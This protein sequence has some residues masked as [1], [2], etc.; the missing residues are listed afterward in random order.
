M[1]R[2]SFAW[3]AGLLVLAV[4]VLAP[5]TVT[6]AD[7]PGCSD[8]SRLADGPDDAP[9][10]FRAAF[11]EAVDYLA[12][13]DH[14]GHGL[15][16]PTRIVTCADVR[17]EAAG[18]TA[19]Y[20][21]VTGRATRCVILVYPNGLSTGGIGSMTRAS[22]THEAFHCFM[23]AAL[24]SDART[25]YDAISGWVREGAAAWVGEDAVGG[26]PMSGTWWTS[27][28][29]EPGLRLF[30]RNYSG[31]GFYA[32]MVESG[33]DL[34]PLFE[35]AFRAAAGSTPTPVGINP[36]QF[37]FA[38]LVNGNDSSLDTWPAGL[39]RD[40]SLGPAWDTSGPGITT[41]AAT[42]IPLALGETLSVADGAQTVR[43][44]DLDGIV[45]LAIERPGTHAPGLLRA[46]DGKQLALTT[47]TWC[48][49]DGGCACPDGSPGAAA[50]AALPTV[51]SGSAKLAVSG[52]IRSQAEPANGTVLRFEQVA[53]E[54][55]CAASPDASGTGSSS[56]APVAGGSP[57][58]RYANPGAALLTN[59]EQVDSLFDNECFYTMNSG[60]TWARFHGPPYTLADGRTGDVASAMQEAI[61]EARAR[62]IGDDRAAVTVSGGGGAVC[63]TPA[64]RPTRN[65]VRGHLF[66]QRG[67]EWV[68]LALLDTRA[69]TFRDYPP[70]CEMLGQLAAGIP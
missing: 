65:D 26:S 61:E 33:N 66:F 11:D 18:T 35:P 47:T 70:L 43:L 20:D 15:A 68:D 45:R 59:L 32:H 21:L 2:L 39:F 25:K 1:G 57:C 55:A 40:P 54:D 63:I 27:Y 17:D 16:V 58:A 41:N 37:A 7:D 36:D 23:Q 62:G 13:A 8:P 64:D 44:L 12:R 6:F 49:R 4:N 53:L 67:Q 34:W 3:V 42:P 46:S 28:L 60:W 51:A 24:G 30:E 14:L 52:H 29:S 19:F 22:M 69:S 31:I 9:F 50:V 10:V 38:V 56:P 5:A 48:G